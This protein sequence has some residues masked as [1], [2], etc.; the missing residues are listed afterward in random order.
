MQ[1]AVA[2][3]QHCV[4]HAAVRYASHSSIAAQELCSFS[5]MLHLA[6]VEL[7]VRRSEV[8]WYVL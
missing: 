1:L 2:Y 8:E 3:K 4:S 7:P 5:K 6:K